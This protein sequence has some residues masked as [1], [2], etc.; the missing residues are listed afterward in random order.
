[1]RDETIDKWNLSLELDRVI[2]IVDDADTMLMVIEGYADSR[3][4][5]WSIDHGE[6]GLVNAVR[7]LKKHL[8][9]LIGVEC[10]ERAED[11]EHMGAI[12][13]VLPNRRGD[14]LG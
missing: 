7:V 2:D 14:E 8:K 6:V 1:M 4:L 12:A 13:L 11:H 3:G 9:A 10:P 5:N